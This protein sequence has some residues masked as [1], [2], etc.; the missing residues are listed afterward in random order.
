MAVS[1]SGNIVTS[2][3]PTGGGSAW[4]A[5]AP[6]T[7]SPYA[8]PEFSA[9]SCP[10]ASLCVAGSFGYVLIST[11]PTGGA[12]T[13][14]AMDIG[15]SSE[16]A[17]L[18]C[19]DASLCV[20]G[21]GGSIV[22]FA[23]QGASVAAQMTQL[24]SVAPLTAVS[25]A[26]DSYCSATSDAGMVFSSNDLGGGTS[27]WTST[28]TET[29][30]T[31]QLTG[32]SCV[33]GS[34]ATSPLC[35]AGDSWGRVSTLPP[36]LSGADNLTVQILANGISGGTPGAGLVTSTP[37]GIDCPGSCSAA[38][39]NGQ[40]VT[41]HVLPD[42]QSIVANV[43]AGCT[44]SS[45][46]AYTGEDCT[47]V[48]ST[49]SPATVVVEFTQVEPSIILAPNAVQSGGPTVD[50]AV[51]GCAS[52]GA[53]S[54]SW[55]LDGTSLGLPASQCSIPHLPLSVGSHTMS[56]TVTDPSGTRT[57]TTS[58]QFTVNPQAGFTWTVEPIPYGDS[59][60]SATVVFDAC[61][62]SA[63]I[64]D[65]AW[66]FGGS[67]PPQAGSNCRVTVSLPIGTVDVTLTAAGVDLSG[68]LSV[69]ESVDVSAQELAPQGCDAFSV[70]INSCLRMNLGNLGILIGGPA[71]P[72]DFV[73]LQAGVSAG[74]YGASFAEIV[75]CDGSVYVSPGVSVSAA[76]SLPGSAI[77]GWG[78]ASNPEDPVAPTNAYIDGF[79]EGAW[80]SAG[81]ELGAVGM[82]TISSGTSSSETGF[83]YDQGAVNAL[84]VSLSG[85]YGV[86]A[87]PGDGAQTCTGGVNAS[88]VFQQLL[89][90]P[91]QSGGGYPTIVMPGSGPTGSAPTIGAG[92]TVN[93]Q[94]TDWLAGSDVTVVIHSTPTQLAVFPT[95]DTGS[96]SINVTLPA[97]L[98]AGS[99]TFVESG[100]GP[101]GQPRSLSFPVT[102]A[103]SSSPATSTTYQA[104]W[105]STIS[106]SVGSAAGGTSVTL[107]GTNFTGASAVHFG[108]H[109]AERFVVD[110]DTVITAI[111]PAGGGT[112]GVTVT[113]P[114][115][116]SVE[117]PTPEFTY[118]SPPGAPTGV[119][120]VSADASARV[121][122]H[123][124]IS[125]GGSVI[126]HYTVTSSP[127]S[128]PCVATGETTCVV[129]G[130][131]NGT[132]YTFGVR[133]TNAI[134]TSS[135]SASS[136]EVTPATGA[137]VPGG[138]PRLVLASNRA[139][140]GRSSV[141][142][143]L[144]CS[145][146]SPCVGVTTLE[147]GSR[148]IGATHF[149]I[150]AGKIAELSVKLSKAGIYALSHAKDHR[151][152]ATETLAVPG[153]SSVVTHAALSY[154]PTSITGVAALSVP[155]IRSVAEAEVACRANCAGIAKLLIG[156]QTLGASHFVLRARRD[157]LVRIG[158]D[159]VGKYVLV[160][161]KDHEVAVI[162]YL[163]VRGYEP[164]L[165]RVTLR[166]AAVGKYPAR[167]QSAPA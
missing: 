95:D 35:V 101:D 15:G 162:E 51:S 123:A 155:V 154:L 43:S 148:T 18:S 110:S 136:N 11:N 92:V 106:P 138:P 93:L 90:V 58:D 139:I 140:I 163:F 38:F 88:P 53:S 49:T 160:H 82:Q 128:R 1:P 109:Q 57:A 31:A 50:L 87:Q 77:L 147:V 117:Y 29:A 119:V 120:A 45:P 158:L 146:R 112:V 76:L 63:G 24:S 67:A 74:P 3:D 115:G 125:D 6:G 32:I 104:P 79:V 65:Y 27:A 60:A 103:P 26:S 99:H 64:L 9:V 134:G 107:T 129:S 94:S 100:T 83:E 156:T 127:A 21:S 144:R 23:P 91:Q 16:L 39:S 102:I 114:G 33:S 4:T 118:A 14:T 66:S 166:D 159:N 44:G 36:T 164:V 55:V 78:Y 52:S 56:L 25:C 149:S 126:T 19:P 13:W 132:S 20:A 8:Y 116:T 48:A 62:Q 113:A 10:D 167:A 75:T 141:E 151:I 121:S 47:L 86:L 122:W 54:Y 165:R 71:R 34:L 96:S 73:V 81:V 7:F 98:S 72:A 105:V 84:G 143:T 28:A 41:L 135:M 22:T 145:I 42:P 157:G 46:S 85:S 142:L 131:T 152:A 17:S 69:P 12:S 108:P 5:N 2:T 70:G 161:A 37:P 150:A 111:S 124:P 130:L 97:D 137:A 153:R 30:F 89:N 68:V 61:S 59:I 133:A 40:Q 80:V